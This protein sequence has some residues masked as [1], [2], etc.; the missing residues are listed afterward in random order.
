M[1]IKLSYCLLKTGDIDLVNAS[2]T[3]SLKSAVWV[4]LVKCLMCSTF[5][6]DGPGEDHGS[7]GIW[8][9]TC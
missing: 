6:V 5:D 8:Y 1:L 9:N 2:N 7:S 3:A 4:L